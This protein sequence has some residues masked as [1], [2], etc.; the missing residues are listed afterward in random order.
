MKK[1]AWSPGRYELGFTRT[2]KTP[3]SKL[4]PSKHTSEGIG[5]VSDFVVGGMLATTTF[6][7]ASPRCLMPG[8]PALGD[9]P[10]AALVAGLLVSGA[11]WVF[12]GEN[13]AALAGLIGTGA[14]YGLCKILV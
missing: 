5:I 12:T 8:N 2:V 3:V 11:W 13:Y 4:G 10:E 9:H 7:I 14:L 1:A 6:M